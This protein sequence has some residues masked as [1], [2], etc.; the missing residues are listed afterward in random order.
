MMGLSTRVVKLTNPLTLTDYPGEVAW[1]IAIPGCNYRCS[2]CHNMDIAYLNSKLET[3]SLNNA[4]KEIPDHI[5]AVVLGGGEPLRNPN[6]IRIAQKLKSLGYKV[7][8]QTNGY[9]NTT[10][11]MIYPYVDFIA[12][13]VKY[14][15]EK[16]DDMIITEKATKTATDVSSRTISSIMLITKYFKS[17]KQYEFRTTAVPYL[18]KEDL[19][20]IARSLNAYGA[21][22]YYIQKCNVPFGWKPD[23]PHFGPVSREEAIEILQNSGIQNTGVRW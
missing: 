12:M 17:P 13:D 16:L 2:T 4:I 14:P 18:S 15:I 7:G 10:I 20:S 8:I 22:T 11:F 23:L 9:E 19:V 21:H 6:I 5:K 3:I 1:M